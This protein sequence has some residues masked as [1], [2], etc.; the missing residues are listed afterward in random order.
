M[1][2]KQQTGIR[3]PDELFARIDAYAERLRKEQPGLE[4]NRAMAIRLLITKGLDAVEQKK[5]KK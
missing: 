3:L 4:V 5:P 2:Q 1:V